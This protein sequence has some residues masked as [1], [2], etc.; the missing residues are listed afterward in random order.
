MNVSSVSSTI[1]AAVRSAETENE[2]SI[3]MAS[4]A[5][6]AQKQEGANALQLIAAATGKGHNVDFHA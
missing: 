2:I 1:A 3:T 4:K 5:M 6:D